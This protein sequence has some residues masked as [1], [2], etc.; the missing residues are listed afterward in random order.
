MLCTEIGIHAGRCWGGR[1]RCREFPCSIALTLA[2]T[3]ICFPPPTTPLVLH[4]AP[5]RLSEGKAELGE[6][7]IR[8][9]MLV[10]VSYP[11]PPG[12]A[13]VFLPG[14]LEFL[15]PGLGE[16]IPP[17]ALLLLQGCFPL[18]LGGRKCSSLSGGCWVDLTLPY[19]SPTVWLFKLIL[20]SSLPSPHK[21][22]RGKIFFSLGGES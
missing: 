22:W 3:M 10:M 16:G 14:H 20:G 1:G 12:L 15:R 21:G 2:D 11:V 19:C 4:S 13:R 7:G 8:L 5:E 6:R 17:Q 18:S 9:F